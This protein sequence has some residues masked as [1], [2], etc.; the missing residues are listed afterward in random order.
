MKKLLLIMLVGVFA[1]VFAAEWELS[2]DAN[3]MFALNNYSDNWTGGDAG[4][5]NWTAN[6][7][8][9]AEKQLAEWL[10]NKNLLQLSF[11]QTHIQKAETGHWL[12]PEKSTDLIDFETIFRFTLHSFV[13]P[14]VAGRLQSQFYDGRNKLNKRY[15]NPIKLTESAGVA[16][17][18]LKE[19][20]REWTA[21]L[22]FGVRQYID[23]DS[24]I[25]IDPEMNET[26]TSNDGGIEFVSELRTPLAGDKISYNTRLSVFEALFN[27]DSDELVGMPNEDY[28]KAPDIEWDH[29]FAAN[30]TEYLMVNLYIQILYDKEISLR[31]SH[32]ETISLGLTYKLF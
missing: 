29:T 17:V 5:I 3:A 1:T 26:Q 25:T 9:L 19:E 32:K 11:G 24:I 10:N 31:G 21:R 30:I 18:L 6:I 7:D 2:L 16:R 15:F 22:G 28:W 8:G 12:V 20:K 14:Y 4:G 13:D 23:R 27:S